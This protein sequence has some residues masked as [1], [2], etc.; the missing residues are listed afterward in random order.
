MENYDVI[1][2]GA[3]AM[4]SA[5]AYY[6][7]R[8]GYRVLLLEQFDLQHEKGSSNDHSRII[9]YAYDHPAY[10]TLMRA[11][12]PLWHALE[13]ASQT[14]LYVQTG[15][16]DIGNASDPSFAATR[17]CLAQAGI[18][19]EI[20]T[21]S[22]AAARFPMFRFDDDVDIIYQADTGILRAAAAVAV[23]LRL[24]QQH[25]A[26][27]RANVG[28]SRLV[29]HANSVE[30]HADT[31]YR[32]DRLV[33]AAGAWTNHLLA[34]VGLSLPLEPTAVQLVYF[35]TP[36]D[37]SLDA[38]TMPVFITHQRARYGD[39]VY[40]IPSIHGSGVKVAFHGGIRTKDVANIDYTPDPA[41]VERLRTY[42]RRYLPSADRP[43][44]TTRICLY[45][46]TPD[47]HFVLDLHPEHRHIVVASPCSGHGFKFSTLF[48]RIL[49][50]MAIDG[51]TSHN[52]DLFSIARFL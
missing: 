20:L 13:E 34:N 44:R 52:T 4:G 18:P 43:V 8:D 45:T 28:V 9:R 29:A 40:G 37:N 48:G 39:W 11:A 50:D 42:V 10:I 33:L 46:M 51:H 49:A 1:V 3:G 47:E 5:A 25:G 32:A 6:L 22:E 21:P 36:P 19:H 16:L 35:E 26:V 27:V 30:V 12:Y 15:G 38:G 31:V 7:A 17:Q 41:V 14:T 23:H 24:A 2:V